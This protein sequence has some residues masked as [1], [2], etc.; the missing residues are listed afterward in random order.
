MWHCVDLVLTNISLEHIT[1]VLRVAKSVRKKPD[2]ILHG[3]RCESLK[4]YTVFLY[5]EA[6]HQHTR[7]IKTLQTSHPGSSRTDFST[8]KMEAICS[9]ETSVNTR[10]TQRHILEDN[11]THSHRCKSLKSY[12]FNNVLLIIKLSL[13]IF[14]PM[15]AII[16]RQ[17]TL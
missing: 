14:Q 4:S 1:S 9:S 8:L 13:Y 2:N 6:T 3:H 7:W 5:G 16:R 11:I 15:M 10:A 17:T 12:K